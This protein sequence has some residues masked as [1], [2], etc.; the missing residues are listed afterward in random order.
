[1]CVC[2]CVYTLYTA[3]IGRI[4]RQHGLEPMFYA[5]DSQ[6]YITFRPAVPGD[7][8]AMDRITASFS[9][10]RRWMLANMLQLN[11][12]KT[13]CLII[14]SPRLRSTIQTDSISMGEARIVPAA[15]ARNLGVLFD[16]H[17]DLERYIKK[18]CQVAY[19]HLRN[20]SAIR[21]MLT[22][23]AA[24][25]IINA[26]VTSRLDF[27]NS[28]LIGLPEVQLKGLGLPEVQL[29]GLQCVQNA[30]ARLLTGTGKYDHITPVLQELHWLPVVCRVQYKIILLTYKALQGLAPLY[31]QELLSYRTAWPGLRSAGTLNIPR[32]RQRFGYRS[33]ACAAPHL[34]NSLPRRL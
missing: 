11:D 33:F 15:G 8:V 14:Y 32:R 31:L 23:E 20:I 2:V 7:E 6:L 26:F 3:P 27:C 29:K 4:V 22:R 34:W 17:L 19:H 24:E 28:L 10:I 13:E 30:A 21:R 25:T 16:N 12:N 5:D 1:M 9:D 18:T